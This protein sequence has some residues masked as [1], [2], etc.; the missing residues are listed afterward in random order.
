MYSFRYKSEWSE[1]ST[2][3]YLYSVSFAV[4]ERVRAQKCYQHKHC[5]KYLSELFCS[6]RLKI[7]HHACRAN[8]HIDSRWKVVNG[9]GHS[10]WADE[11]KPESQH[12]DWS[13]LFTCLFLSQLATVSLDENTRSS[14]WLTSS[15]NGVL[16]IWLTGHFMHPHTLLVRTD[17]SSQSIC[18]I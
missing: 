17:L 5:A 2:L 13:L 16:I 1:A 4:S 3:L 6:D 18:W 15:S 12:T 9:G 10:S 14:L 7:H 8:N 11:V